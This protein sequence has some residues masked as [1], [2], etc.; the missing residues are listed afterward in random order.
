MRN[1]LPCNPLAV[2]ALVFLFAAASAPT[3][4]A[5]APVHTTDDYLAH[6]TRIT[7]L[8]PEYTVLV[9][10]PFVIAGNDTPE[11]LR[12]TGVAVV[13]W[14]VDRLKQDYFDKDPVDIIDIYLYKDKASYD[15][16]NK[17]IFPGAPDTPY[18]Y[19]SPTHKALVMNISTGGG[20]LVHEIVHP[21]MAANFP[22]DGPGRGCPTWFNEGLAS[23]YEQSTDKEGHIWGLPNWRLTDLKTNLNGTAPAAE[24]KPPSFKTLCAM[25][26]NTFYGA[27]KSP[28]YGTARYLLLYLQEKGV[29]RQFYKDFVKNYKTDPTGYD[30]LTKTLAALGDKDMDAFRKKWEAWVMTLKYP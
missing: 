11:N 25:D 23:L 12:N 14:T 8:H 28:N 30:T 29:L 3:S 19:Y 13:K 27:G 6:V 10:K 1:H 20:T 16:A 26:A 2:S 9:Q 22:A 5:T 24:G 4:T 17:T 7:G 21:F 18:G 15:D